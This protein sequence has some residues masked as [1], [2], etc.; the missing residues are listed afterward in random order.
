MGKSKRL[1]DNPA[2]T[3]L[4]GEI[5]ALNGKQHNF[6]T[7]QLRMLKSELYETRL[8]LIMS[9]IFIAYITIV[10]LLAGK[11]AISFSIATYI[12]IGGLICFSV[13]FH[14]LK[15]SIFKTPY[16]LIL[17]FLPMF[18]ILL[19]YDSL[20]VVAEELIFPRVNTSALYNTDHTLFA[21][22][23]GGKMPNEWFYQTFSCIGVDLIFG[24]TYMLHVFVPIIL[25]V[26]FLLKDDLKSIRYT[27]FLFAVSTIISFV[28]YLAFP[29]AAPWYVSE[30]GFVKP[31]PT[32]PYQNSITAGLG[33]ID[34]LLGIKIFATYYTF[35]SNSFASFPSVH[36]V[37]AMNAVICAYYKW[38]NRSL[39]IMLPYVFAILFG[40]VYFYHHYIIDLVSGIIIS[41][42]AML[43]TNYLFKRRFKSRIGE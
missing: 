18:L 15:K 8:A 16:S 29:T 2:T 21:W 13:L 39:I 11:L 3:T 1:P 40:A 24:F 41:F 37:Y 12:M 30:Y 19:S 20:S 22:I 7:N 9:L 36:V 33:R 14:F 4:E 10:S 23:F 34:D 42:I 17:D 32:I 35:E 5:K 38:K 27:I 25:G 26:I 31:D 28:I 43:F 6:F